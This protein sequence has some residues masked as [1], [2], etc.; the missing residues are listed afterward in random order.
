MKKNLLITLFYLATLSVYSQAA[1]QEVKTV[2]ILNNDLIYVPT[3]DKIYVTTPGA[4]S[5]GNSVCIIDPYTSQVE[6]CFFVGSEPN[7]LAISDNGQYLYIGLDG[8][9]Q[10]VQFNLITKQVTSTFDLGTSTFGDQ[11][12]VEDMKVLFNQPNSVVISRRNQGFSP[13]HEGVAIYDNGIIR[14]NTT[15]DHT[16]SNTIAFDEV[17]GG[18]FGYNNESTEFGFRALTI[19]TSG[20]TE[21]IVRYGLISG[22]ENV[23]E[24]QANAIYSNRGE[25]VRVINGIP[26]LAGTYS[27]PSSIFQSAVEPAPDTNLVYFVTNNFGGGFKLEIFDKNTFIHLETRDLTG[28]FG[29]VKNLINW[30]D[31]GKLAFNT[32]EKVVILRSCISQLTSPLVLSPDQIGGC[33]GERVELSAPAGLLNYRWST[34]DT[35]QTIS[36]DEAGAYFFSV[37]DSS[38]C[39]SPPSNA[40]T[41]E[42]DFKPSTPSIFGNSLIE[43]CQ[44]Q[45]TTLSASFSFGSA[46]YIWST[47]ETTQSIEVT[48]SGFYS[49]AGVS[50]NGCVGDTSNLVEVRASNSTIPD[51]P[52]VVIDGPLEFC[53]GESTILSAP[54]GFGFYRWSNGQSTQTIEVFNTGF[55]SVQVANDAFCFSNPSLGVFINVSPA[56]N[57]PFIQANGNLLASSASQGNQWFLNEVPLP[58]ATGRFH[59]A[60]ESGFY[61]VQVTLDGCAS[62]MSDLFNH[63]LVSLDERSFEKE[64]LVFPNPASHII[65]I[66]YR[67]EPTRKI[68]RIEVFNQ[69]GQS[70]FLASQANQVDISG[71]A[72]GLYFMKLYDENNTVIKVDSFVKIH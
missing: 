33:S 71:C 40:V 19:N 5:N 23:I 6:E 70:I 54:E 44:G 30:G 15:Q 3:E 41:V 24:S 29:E 64:V 35:T 28:I 21:G 20:V 7:K 11:L 31:G 68:S 39:L 26:S 18:L 22:F 14:P 10:V 66:Q 57:A 4:G 16:G 1:S 42:F 72:S 8:A 56:P 69:I 13:K 25:L 65:N 43:L 27:L 59:T 67:N 32:D 12:F 49:V 17:G 34:G 61:S 62:P 58:N 63:L 47:G 50:Q 60:T 36:V 46:S 52:A 9:P 48:S 2:N 45:S 55:Y 51:P 38:G 37:A 53:Q